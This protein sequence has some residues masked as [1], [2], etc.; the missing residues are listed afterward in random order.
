MGLGYDCVIID[1]LSTSGGKPLI[2]QNFC[3]LGGLANTHDE[4]IA[5]ATA[6]KTL[7]SK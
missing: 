5:A 7:C 3:G 6:Q 1:G 4:A 2:F